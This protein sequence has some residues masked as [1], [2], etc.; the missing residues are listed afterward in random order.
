VAAVD[1]AAALR[2]ELA[3]ASAGPRA[4]GAGAA[5]VTTI[6]MFCYFKYCA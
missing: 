1:E 6:M 4:A 3:E 2:A 5:E